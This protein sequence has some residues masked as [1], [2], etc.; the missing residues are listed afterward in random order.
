MANTETTGTSAYAWSPDITSY[1]PGD[2]VPAALILATSTVAGSVEGDAPSVRV[3]YVTDADAGFVPE[4][5][6]IDEAD[7]ALD[8]CVIFTG[9]VAQLI[10]VSREQWLQ[11]GTSTMLSTSVERAIT[12]AA[13]A[14]YLAQAAPTPPAVTPPAGLLNIADIEAA[15][16][17]V[18]GNLDQLV[19]LIA[20]IEGNGGTPSHIVLAPDAWGEISKMK[21][22][23]DYNAALLGAGTD[24]T[25][26]RLLGLPVIVT[27]A[28]TSMTGLVI[29][30]T[31]V[32]SAVGQVQ[33]ATSEHVYFNS[34]DIG[35][36]AT[37]RF[38]A[39]VVHPDRIGSF[40]VAAPIV[41]P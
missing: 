36:R 19:D 7:P 11:R 12:R 2:A 8:E 37:W 17:D 39:N 29:D 1:S 34:D 15:A 28:M 31:A 23:T 14:A 9:K 5:T 30:A 13:N 3:A 18:S 26:R 21:M 25:E 20:T 27:P 41:I 10:R 33:V 24:A 4:G 22:G 16:D 32:V 6:A 40:E 38:G 35:L